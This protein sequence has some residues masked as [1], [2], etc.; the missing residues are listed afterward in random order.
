MNYPKWTLTAL[1]LCLILA[2]CNSDSSG[3]ATSSDD[4]SKNALASDSSMKD[5]ATKNTTSATAANKKKLKASLGE[6][7][8]STTKK[9]TKDK[10]GVYD[11]AEVMPSFKGGSSAIG[12]YVNA[13]LNAPQ[14]AVDDSKE[15]TVKVMFTIDETGQVVN[16]HTMGTKLGDGLD[17]EAVRVVAAMPKWMPG[18]INGKPVKVSLT[19]PIV[20]KAEG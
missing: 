15:G 19:L 11:N 7:A 5:S 10:S 17:E 4:S 18:T 6:M 2:A 20:F 12:D 3:S 13:N 8:A 1:A 16:A 14:N 9:Y